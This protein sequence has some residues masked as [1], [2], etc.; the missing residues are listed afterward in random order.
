MIN[1]TLVLPSPSPPTA[2]SAQLPRIS[3]SPANLIRF[4][5]C[6]RRT[7]I[8]Q[9]IASFPN[10]PQAAC[11]ESAY[12]PS[13]PRA[14]R[15]DRCHPDKK[16]IACIPAAQLDP[17]QSHSKTSHPNCSLLTISSTFDSL[18]RV[19]FNFRSHYLFAIGVTAVF[20]FRRNLPPF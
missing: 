17:N 19:L 11:K 9:R 8:L 1:N 6:P 18:F 20:S 15:V 2:A 5:D 3:A 4:L 13:S 7:L 10:S 12:K 16:P 14:I